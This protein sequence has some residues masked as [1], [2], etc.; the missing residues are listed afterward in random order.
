MS[1]NEFYGFLNSKY[2]VWKYATPNRL[3]K[4]RKQLLRYIE[5]DELNDLRLIKEKLFKRR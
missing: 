5:N 1:I 4:T 3:A 2:F